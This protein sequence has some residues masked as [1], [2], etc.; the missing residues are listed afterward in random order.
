MV[1]GI[2]SG[3]SADKVTAAEVVEISLGLFLPLD[4]RMTEPAVIASRTNL[5]TKPSGFSVILELLLLQLQ[6]AKGGVLSLF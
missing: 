5:G 3:L 4:V 1:G 6:L 2:R